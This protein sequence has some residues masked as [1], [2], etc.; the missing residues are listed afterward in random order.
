MAI[1]NEEA[2]ENTENDER[3]M[4]TTERQQAIGALMTTRVVSITRSSA[5]N[6]S[7]GWNFL[8]VSSVP[9]CT[10]TIGLH[11]GI[12]FR[13]LLALPLPQPSLT[14]C[15]WESLGPA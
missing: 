9:S 11:C 2:D 8:R 7:V 12:E 14:L 1:A 6:M 15:I 4:I 10:H 5:V 13:S 3:T